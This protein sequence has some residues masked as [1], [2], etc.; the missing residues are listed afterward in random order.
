MTPFVASTFGWILAAFAAAPGLEY[1]PA[2]VEPASETRHGVTVPDPYRWMEE[3]DSEETKRWVRAEEELFRSFVGAVPGRDEMRRRILELSDRELFLAPVKAGGRYFLTR[4]TSTGVPAG[5]WVKDSASSRPR[6]LI[7]AESRGAEAS[8]GAFTPS[9][10]G[11][12]VAYTAGQRASGWLRIRVADAETGKDLTVPSL[13]THTIAGAPVWTPDGSEFFFVRFE[14][15]PGS[16]ESTA[17][18][19]RPTV[20]RYRVADRG[21]SLAFAPPGEPGL[22]VSCNVSD[23]GLYLVLTLRDGSSSKNRVLVRSLRR[24]AEPV[25]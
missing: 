23:D 2:R 6:L 3:L 1:P 17:P 11:K 21:E 14:K 20:R 19:V 15:D 5:L 25:P 9:P 13:E 8:L 7:D 12:L 16:S 18:P 24:P 4:I 10:N 22:L